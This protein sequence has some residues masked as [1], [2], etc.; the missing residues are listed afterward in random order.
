MSANPTPPLLECQGICRTHRGKGSAAATTVLRDMDLAIQPGEFVALTGASGSGKSTLLHLLGLL[1]RPD[2]GRLFL[3]GR[4]VGACTAAERAA[5]RRNLIGYVFQSFNLLGTMTARE[6]VALPLLYSGVSRQSALARA[7]DLLNHL[8][9]P[10]QR[11][12]VP[13]ELSGGQ[14]QRVAL[15][16][17]LANRPALLLADEPTGNLDS[18]SAAQVMQLLAELHRTEALTLVL[19]THDAAVAAAA[20]RRLS[21]RDGRLYRA[22]EAEA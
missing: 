7:D 21:L 15:A 12:R 14:Q 18:A 11:G 19:V 17:A 1:D 20:Q 16:R 3:N 9:L 2:S 10:E 6:N 22:A 8:G 4:D 5:L 13:H